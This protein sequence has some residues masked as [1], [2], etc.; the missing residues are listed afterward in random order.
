MTVA[1][2]TSLLGVFLAVAMLMGV[3]GAGLAA[4]VIGAAGLAAREGVGMFDRLPGD[5][6]QNPL[7]QQSKILT[8]DGKVLSTPAEQNRIIVESKDISQHMK[9]AQV[10]IEDERFYE[11][12]GLD[13]EALARAVVSNATSDT[14][15]GGST[16]TQQ[17]IKLALKDQA[18]KERD[19]EA[20]RRVE[21]RSGMEGYVRKLRELKYAV[22]LEERLTKDEILTGYLNLSFYGDNVYG[23]EAAARHYFNVRAKDLS[24]AQAATLAGIVRSPTATNPV[25]NMELATARRNTV[26][27]KMYAQDMITEKEWRKAKASE[28]ELDLTD[29]QRSCINSSNPYFCDYV[30]AWLLRQP[31]LGATVAERQEKLTTGGLTITTTLQPELSRNLRKILRETTPKNKYNIGSAATIIEPGTGKVLAFNQSSKYTFDE[32]GDKVRR[33]AVDWNVDSAY[34][35]PGGFELG[36]VAKA[37]T[38]VTALE[39]GVPVEAKID[40]PEP[41][42]ADSKGVW[43]NNPEDPQ[44]PDGETH[45]VAVFKKED[46]QK[47][48]TI[49]EDYWTVRNAADEN[50]VPEIS[51]RKATGLSINTAFATLASQVGTCDIIETMTR[52]G[53]HDSTGEQFSPYPP[54]I[55][56]GSDYAS[57]MTVASSYA[58]FASG[59]IY[60]P[61]VPVTKVVDS[62]GKEIPL[63]LPG[64]ERVIDKEVALG[65]V[66]LLK[67]VVSP[68]GSGWKAILDGN[69]PAGGKTGTN[70][71]SSHTWFAGFTKQLSIAVFVGVPTGAAL[72][73]DRQDLTIGDTYI[74]GVLYGSSLAAPTWKRIM[75]MAS[76]GMPIEDW[77]KPSDE[78]LNGKRVTIPAVIGLDVEA[79][80]DKLE[81]AGLTASL[82]DV[83]S[84]QPEGTVVYTTPGIGSSI[85]T[86]TPVVL[87][88]STGSAPVPPP[89]A[90]PPP[91]NSSPPSSDEDASAPTA[92]PPADGGG[93]PGGGGDDGGGGGRGSGGGGERPPRPP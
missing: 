39:K 9:D 57:P 62:D 24:I 40:L 10:A 71:N 49:G 68:S 43:I 15:Q 61:P 33:T 83:S 73:A 25:A 30:T 28:I 55:V 7:A 54:A 88:V 64:C 19:A 67:G 12:G 23:V 16:L 58:T 5:L 44:V 53:M 20:L 76:E 89:Q 2:V 18:L 22:T 29:S 52:M 90:S 70:N 51:L 69:R 41:Q 65:A 45:P 21:A 13:V 35:G 11:H 77:E 87:H 4:P 37:Y 79:A 86:S 46:F 14:T 81:D 31:A 66:E 60:C 48:C 38:V 42:R 32:S 34:G 1:R 56:L 93:G 84:R 63:D 50:H 26:L 27:D 80:K 74:D 17:Y 3:I 75:D 82:Q 47:G 72:G 59:G 36:S 78:I 92:P 6:D 8:A 85:R 91:S